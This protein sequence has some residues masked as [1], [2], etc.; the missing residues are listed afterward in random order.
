MAFID[1]EVFCFVVGFFLSFFF[2]N[3]IKFVPLQCQGK[4]FQTQLAKQES[5]LL[6]SNS[7]T[8]VRIFPPSLL[9]V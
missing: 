6:N 9:A 2:K 7:R 1:Q 3:P 5:R 4:E 8:E